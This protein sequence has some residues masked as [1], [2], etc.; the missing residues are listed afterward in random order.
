[1][2]AAT[3][4]DQLRQLTSQRSDPS[5]YLANNLN[6][7]AAGLQNLQRSGSLG[8]LNQPAMAHNNAAA[9]VAAAAAASASAAQFASLVGMQQNVNKNAMGLEPNYG[10]DMLGLQQSFN[11]HQQQQPQQRYATTGF[12]Q[13]GAF[14][15]QHQHNNELAGQAAANTKLTAVLNN[16]MALQRANSLNGHQAVGDM[17]TAAAPHHQHLGGVPPYTNMVGG[18]A[19]MQP[20]QLG[21]HPNGSMGYNFGSTVPQQQHDIAS[22]SA[23]LA[24]QTL[25]SFSHS[26][27]F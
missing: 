2:T 15:Q 4:A 13:G 5:A 12:S 16:L 27:E 23:L 10:T 20:S 7:G 25:S 26:R 19:S 11:S 14:N 6:M 8:L 9:A 1:M 24:N 3:L 18:G 22:L 17:S 21:Q